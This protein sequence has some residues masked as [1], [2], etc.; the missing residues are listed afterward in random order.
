MDSDAVVSI[1]EFLLLFEDQQFFMYI[2][3][4]DDKTCPHCMKL[5][6]LLMTRREIEKRFPFLIKATDTVWLPYTHPNS[7]CF[8]ILWEIDRK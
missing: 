1:D 7:R 5:N 4:G 2:A 6:K 8:L 3:D